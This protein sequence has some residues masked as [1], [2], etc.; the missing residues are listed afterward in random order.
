MGSN[1]E[2]LLEAR[3]LRLL[4]KNCGKHIELHSREPPLSADHVIKIRAA[5]LVIHVHSL[6]YFMG[7]Y[8]RIIR[9]SDA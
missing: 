6:F 5:I 4:L 1:H 7:C 2:L 8:A 9:L 3:C